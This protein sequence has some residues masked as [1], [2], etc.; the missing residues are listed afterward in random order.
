VRATERVLPA[1]DFKA[2]FFQD[3]LQTGGLPGFLLMMRVA[4]D[5][6]MYPSLPGGWKGLDWLVSLLFFYLLYPRV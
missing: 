3:M 2:R 1:G 5:G 6:D 4:Y